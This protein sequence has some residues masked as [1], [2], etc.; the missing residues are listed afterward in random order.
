MSRIILQLIFSYIT[1]MYMYM[2]IILI[3]VCIVNVNIAIGN[4]DLLVITYISQEKES[5]I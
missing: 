2:Y 4:T 1:Y 5:L 3:H